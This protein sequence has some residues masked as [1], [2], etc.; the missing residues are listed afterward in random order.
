VTRS[1]GVV[2]A[3]AIRRAML[4]D[5]RAARPRECCGL[6]VGT[7]RR[8]MFAVPMR[9]VAPGTTRYR[10]D[11]AEHIAVRRMMRRLVPAVE[12]VGVYHSHPV[13]P[14][15]PSPTDVAEAFYPGW[16]HLIVG[17]RPKPDVRA[18]RIRGG[19]VRPLRIAWR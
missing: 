16:I 1:T 5:A 6:L 2:M 8:V 18:F 17:L 9:N 7:G 3:R 13:G 15:R 12:L 11:A 4:H 19:R 10:L 14:A